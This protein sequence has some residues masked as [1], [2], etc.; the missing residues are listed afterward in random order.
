MKQIIFGFISLGSFVI[1]AALLYMI[2]SYLLLSL[3]PFN[4][5]VMP[6]TTSLIAVVL[7]GLLSVCLAAYAAWKIYFYLAK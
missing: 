4:K 5:A 2:V 7:S 6:D 3:P 1:S